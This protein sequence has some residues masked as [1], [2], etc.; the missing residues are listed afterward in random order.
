MKTA[1]LITTLRMLALPAFGD[2]KPNFSGTWKLNGT[3]SKFP[4]GNPPVMTRTVEQKGDSLHYKM[5]RDINGTKSGFDIEVSIGD[6]NPE[7]AATAVWEGAVLV[8][9]LISAPQHLRQIEHRKLVEGGKRL[10]DETLVK[11][12]DGTETKILRVFDKL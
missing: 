7:A 11:R 3:A 6:A 2:Q 8:V 4:N 1:P 5:E 12:D 9:T 10:I